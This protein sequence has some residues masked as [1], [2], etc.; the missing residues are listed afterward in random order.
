MGCCSHYAT[1]IFYLSYYRHLDFELSG[2]KPA[3]FLN[4]VLVTIGSDS[5]LSDEEFKET[6]SNEKSDE[7]TSQLIKDSMIH[8]LSFATIKTINNS[9]KRFSKAHDN[10]SQ[11]P[12]LCS[13]R[14]FSKKKPTWG[15]NI[16]VYYCFFFNFQR[17]KIVNTCTIDYPLFGLW[18]SRKLTKSS[19]SLNTKN[20][21][22]KH[23]VKIIR[24]IDNNE[25]DR[26][27]SIWI[28]KFMCFSPD[29]SNRFSLY[30]GV[31]DSFIKHL[32]RLQQHVFRC[33]CDPSIIRRMSDLKFRKEG[34][35][36]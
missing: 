15:G 32:I 31:Y 34:D 19:F 29:E 36:L 20:I 33:S 24:H 16:N 35:S 21:L 5:E 11:T 14:E 9:S 13:Y 17:K 12:S 23:L 27:K 18:F 4:S 28:L 3:S 6:N 25:W 7:G 26:A 2:S 10:S 22:L 8:S 30:G 1:L